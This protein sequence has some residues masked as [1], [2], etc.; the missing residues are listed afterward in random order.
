MNVPREK[1]KACREQELQ[2][3]PSAGGWRCGPR[4]V[5]GSH[6][7]PTPQALLMGNC[8]YSVIKV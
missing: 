2:P 4:A 7:S 5:L 1:M 3:L 8:G 6:D